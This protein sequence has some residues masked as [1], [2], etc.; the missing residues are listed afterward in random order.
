MNTIV[1][2]AR[3]DEAHEVPLAELEASLHDSHARVWVDLEDT[4]AAGF[5]AL[6]P[7]LTFHPMIGR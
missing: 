6:Q 2:V 5:E 7:A 4:G 1:T 3:K